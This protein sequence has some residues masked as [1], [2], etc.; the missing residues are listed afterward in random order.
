VT[1]PDGVN[2]V[3]GKLMAM[4]SLEMRQVNL[5]SLIAGSNDSVLPTARASCTLARTPSP[6]AQGGARA[7]PGADHSMSLV[8]PWG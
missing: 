3:I 7:R 1:T 2:G 5:V 6:A 8:R 4:P